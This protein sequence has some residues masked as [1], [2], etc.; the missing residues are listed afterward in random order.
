MA[1]YP[2]HKELQDISQ[3]M[4]KGNFGLWYNKFIPLSDA[5]KASDDHGK[6]TMSVEHYSTRYGQMKNNA[7]DILKRKHGYLDDFCTIFPPKQYEEINIPATLNAPLI[8]GIG[9]SHPHEISMVFDHNMGIPYIPASGVKGIVRFVH[10]LAIVEKG[11]PNEWIQQ[12][13]KTGHACFDDDNYEPIY[14]IFG[15]QKNRGRVVFLDAYPEKVPAL[16]VDIMNPHYGD[17][18]SDDKGK[19]PPADYLSPNPIKFLTVAAGTIFIFRAIA[20][21]TDNMPEKVRAAFMKALTVEGVGA[22]TSVGYGRFAVVEEKGNVPSGK[23]EHSNT[24]ER[25]PLE[26]WCDA[27]K[28]IKPNDAGKIGSTIDNALKGLISEDDKQKFAQ[29]VKDHMGSTF[30]GSKAKEKLKGYLQ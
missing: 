25:T 2:V 26:K 30:K 20:E 27:V 18:Y 24:Q 4:P 10:T 17:Y 15:N 12:D 1:F 5:F 14:S 16:H 19:T 29:A 22:K 6:E 8:T 13:K 3:H 28:G 23:P 21:K 11:L 9:E 7:A